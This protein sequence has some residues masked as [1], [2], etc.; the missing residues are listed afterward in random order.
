MKTFCTFL[1]GIQVSVIA[2]DTSRQEVIDLLYFGYEHY[3]LG[4]RR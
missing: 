3:H 1:V 2:A 4:H